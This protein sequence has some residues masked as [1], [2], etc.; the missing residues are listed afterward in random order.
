[1]SKES[2]TREFTSYGVVK[3]RDHFAQIQRCAGMLSEVQLWYR[4]NDKSNSVANLLLHLTG[5]IRQWIIGGIAGRPIERERQAEFDARGGQTRDELLGPLE[6]VINEACA[7]VRMLSEQDLAKEYEIQAYTISGIAAVMH[8][9]EHFAFHT[10]Q[11]ITTTKWL[12]NVDLSLYDEKGHRRD[13]R[14]E[15]VP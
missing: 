8:V 3:L 13:G 1:M 11:I 4:A 2:L 5:N 15:D 6:E 14:T 10:G 9:V 7:V 12:L